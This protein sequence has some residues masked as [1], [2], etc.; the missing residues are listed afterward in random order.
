MRASWK[1][2]RKDDFVP[3]QTLVETDGAREVIFE[4]YTI[5]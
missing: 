4:I 1:G 2:A 3:L 5:I